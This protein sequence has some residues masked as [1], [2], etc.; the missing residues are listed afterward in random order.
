[1]YAKAVSMFQKG[2]QNGSNFLSLHQIIHIIYMT[3]LAQR[4]LLPI[5]IALLLSGCGEKGKSE[6]KKFTLDGR[7][8]GTYYHIV[9]YHL[10]DKEAARA[11]LPNSN[12]IKRGIDSIFKAIDETLSLWNP[13][14]I[15]SKVN[16]NEQVMLNDIFIDN[17]QSAQEFSR[18]T[19]GCFDITIA[20]IVKAQG[21]A[22]EQ[23]TKTDKQQIDSLMQYVGYDKVKIEN[24]TIKKLYPQTQLDFN[25]IAQGYTSDKVSQYLTKNNICSHIVDVGGEVYASNR[26]PDGQQWRV[27]IEQPS[28]TPNAQ[29]E[30]NSFIKIENQ[31][32]VTSGNYRKFFVENGIKYTHTIDPKTGQNAKHSLLSV[33]VVAKT[34]TTADALAT[35]FMVMGME[36]AEAFIAKHPEYQA[37][38]IYCDT[39]GKTKTKATKGLQDQIEILK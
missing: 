2:V 29:R 39:D 33:S 12:D 10:D 3:R 11:K 28:E 20:P 21:F 31:S 6:L 37:I 32:I 18:L 16:A 17:F 38:F 22:N 25:A 7:V 35:A 23:R 36:K 27:A 13:N 14:S 4:C 1:M 5:V 30:Y 24:N 26:K 34:A 19:D 8:Q 15:V 9:Y